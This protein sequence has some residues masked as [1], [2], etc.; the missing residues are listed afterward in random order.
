M[1]SP[2]LCRPGAKAEPTDEVRKVALPHS[3]RVHDAHMG[4]LA[5]FTQQVDAAA[6]KAEPLGH[7]AH[8]EQRRG[9]LAS[10]SRQFHMFRLS[11]WQ[12]MGSKRRAK[13]CIL[14]Q[15]PGI[16]D[17]RESNVSIYLQTRAIPSP[18]SV[19]PEAAGSSPVH[20]AD[21][22]GEIPRDS[23]CLDPVLCPVIHPCLGR[24]WGD[25]LVVV[26]GELRGHALGHGRSPRRHS[27]ASCRMDLRP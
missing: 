5:T 7:L 15:H 11:P 23:L 25:L 10:S 16:F 27:R 2:P 18:S 13:A 19:T 1:G 20:P 14:L 8:I 4:K 6:A 24:Q 17:F 22:L 3:D 21:P 9:R 26:A 12:Q